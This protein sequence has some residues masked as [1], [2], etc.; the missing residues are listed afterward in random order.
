M[1]MVGYVADPSFSFLSFSFFSFLARKKRVIKAPK[2]VPT[3]EYG[4][5]LQEQYFSLPQ[6]LQVAI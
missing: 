6:L 5:S 3:P 2:N 4:A 1:M